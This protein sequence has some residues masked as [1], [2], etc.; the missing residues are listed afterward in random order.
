M[1]SEYTQI[2]ITLH[3]LQVPALEEHSFIF[4]KL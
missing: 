4:S 3:R 2:I 1:V